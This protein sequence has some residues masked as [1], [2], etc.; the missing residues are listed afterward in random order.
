MA[1]QGLFSRIPITINPTHTDALI[2]SASVARRYQLPSGAAKIL[3]SATMD[4]NILLGDST[5]TA[6]IPSTDIT[7]GGAPFHNPGMIDVPS[8]VTHVSIIGAENGV[9]YISTWSKGAI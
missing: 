5:I 7:N 6:T 8:D 1:I 4:F 3:V 9:A 2:M